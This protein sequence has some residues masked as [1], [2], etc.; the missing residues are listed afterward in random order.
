MGEFPEGDK[1]KDEGGVRWGDEGSDT[2]SDQG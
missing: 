2:G 1:D